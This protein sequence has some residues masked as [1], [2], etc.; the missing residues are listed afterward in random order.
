VTGFGLLGHLRNLLEASGLEARLRLEDVPA[1]DFALPL[2]REGLVPGGS[3]H[4]LEYAAAGAGVR[5]EAGV[6]EGARLLLADAQTSGG[7]LIA[8]SEA[9]CAALL[10]ELDRRGARA[11]AVVGELHEGLPGRVTVEG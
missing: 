10:E 1:F 7:L 6:D 9:R 2:A 8:V 4:N 11:R 5:F 3:R